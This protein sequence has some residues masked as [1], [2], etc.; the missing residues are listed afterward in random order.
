[1]ADFLETSGY[2]VFR[3]LWAILRAAPLP[4][5]RALLVALGRVAGVVA[6]PRRRVAQRNLASVF[7]QWSAAERA[8]VA[9]IVFGNWGRMAAEVVHADAMMGPETRQALARTSEAVA[10]ARAGGHGVLVL[11]AH[12]GNFE[13]LLRLWGRSGERIGVF[14]RRMKNRSLDRLLSEGRAADGVQTIDRGASVR[15]ALELLRDGVVLV[16][17]L[18]QNQKPGHGIFVPFFGRTAS[19]STALARLS[20]ATGAPVLPVF[21]VWQGPDTVPELGRLVD[22]A[23]ERPQGPAGEVRALWIERLTRRYS[24]EIEALVRR[25]P[26]QWNWAHERWKTRPPGDAA[27]AEAG[28][29]QGQD[30]RGQD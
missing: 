6:L 26:E 29:A 16:V 25:H 24:Q 7:P 2:G 13:L 28:P 19:T 1:M 14:H 17:P 20:V 12:T 15:R 21:A 11:T 8:R 10:A 23:E 30:G 27:A 18:D 3:A 9:R 5:T 22:P 4:W